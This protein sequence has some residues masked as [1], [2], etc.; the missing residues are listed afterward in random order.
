[1]ADVVR[2]VE[3][4]FT[5]SDKA[6]AKLGK[7]HQSAQRVDSMFNKASAAV[8]KFGPIAAAAAGGFSVA[9]AISGAHQYLRT[10]RDISA[11]TG[12]TASGVDSV[13]EA[14]GT[15]NIAAE[16]GQGII[17]QMS[18]AMQRY[19]M[20]VE[21][22]GKAQSEAAVIIERMGLN[23]KKGP[24]AVFVRMAE[25]A[26]MGKVSMADLNIAFQVAPRQA[27]S[28][29]RL[30]QQGPQAVGKIM[31]DLQKRGI[32]VNATNIAAFNKFEKAQLA[33]KSAWDRIFILVAG[34]VMPV[35]G[36]MLEG[37]AGKIDSWTESAA[38]FGETLSK[39]LKSHLDT[40]I[41]IGKVMAANVALQ[42]IS[43]IG[44]GG[45]AMRLGG[46]VG[47]MAGFGGAAAKAVGGVSAAA[48]L[49]L[50]QPVIIAAVSPVVMG[51]IAM[52][53][54]GGGLARVAGGVSKWAPAGGALPGGG[55]AAMG[56]F[57][58]LGQVFRGIGT[59]FVGL[60]ARIPILGRLVT[61]APVLGRF[62]SVVL[63]LSAV[64]VMI[65]A[66]ITAVTW[67][68][69]AV[70]DNVMGIRDI[71]VGWWD[72]VSARVA[73]IWD[74]VD[75]LFKTLGRM[76]STD[77]PVGHFFVK[78]LI[79]VIDSVGTAADQILTTIQMIILVVQK[80]ATN[81]TQ[82]ITDPIK[83]FQSAWEE[84]NRR[85]IAKREQIEFERTMPGLVGIPGGRGAPA[86]RPPPPVFDFRG[87]R[88]DIKQQFVE[89]FDP[90]RIAVAFSNDLATLGERRVQS[91][92]APLFGVR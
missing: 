49:A 86:A 2:Q 11:A 12:F 33:I 56:F 65:T 5:I 64:G 87:S 10:V 35:I 57:A 85:T 3:H 29:L 54:R 21:K 90:D 8:A 63:R 19:R 61:L 20:E 79:K 34:R 32:A 36:D 88:F 72:Q 82:A 7:M 59:K 14:M 70:R 28:M 41:T 25:M 42:K 53:T 30:L 1:M 89:G 43:G 80:M 9:T 38:A 22:S 4:Q 91:G 81:F 66:I 44:L 31:M 24:E 77:G 75:P 55:P 16:E 39:F 74:I 15:V 60:F 78:V 83:L 46:A 48:K 27:S 76:F 50:P 13:L 69:T 71:I 67:T 84:A 68:Y 26:E 45:A 23:M 17:E 52:M 47:K 37:V 92:L 58:K 6:T 40:V 51:Q 62:A 73:V 18:I